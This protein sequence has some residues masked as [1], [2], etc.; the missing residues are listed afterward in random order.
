MSDGGAPAV[1][2]PAAV[3][4]PAWLR[5]FFPGTFA[6]VMATGIVSIAAHLLGYDAVVWPLLGINL[7]AYPVLWVILLA[8][9]ARFPRTVLR[10]FAS[11]DG[12]PPFFTLVAATAVLGSQLADFGVLDG[13]VVPLLWLSVALW[14]VLTYG[15]LS[16]VTVSIAKPGLE[17]GL[18][19]AWLLL[20]VATESIAVLGSYVAVHADQPPLVFA[21]LAFYL[22]GAMLYILLAALIFFRWVFR[23]MH[24]AEMGA[25]WWINMGAVAIAT[26]AGARLV[27][28][29]GLDPSLLGTQHFV[30]T[31]TVMLWAT[32]TFWIPL[33]LILF[34]W[35]ELRRGPYGY[36]P[37]LW[38]VVFPL[39]MYAAATH[40]YAAAARLP[41]LEPIPQAMFWVALL[42]WVLTFVGMGVQLLGVGPR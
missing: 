41:F 34:A 7:A 23:P 36:D 21:C 29:R 12:G 19:G 9:I 4:G 33:L 38:S 5:D 13:L 6:L 3:A 16:A 17:H 1:A 27:L 40:A 30:G 22:L 14:A 10:E 18:N 20:V 25:P 15:F 24:P 37:G 32:S 42:A 28:L 8:R 39:G 11:H 2:R 31:F 35:K 26:L